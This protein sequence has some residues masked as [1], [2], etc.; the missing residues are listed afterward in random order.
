MA[1]VGQHAMDTLYL[2]WED[3]V[4]RA[5][6]RYEIVK[7]K[8]ARKEYV[9]QKRFSDEVLTVTGNAMDGIE[10]LRNLQ[11]SSLESIENL[12][13]FSNIPKEGMETLKNLQKSS[14]EKLAA[15]NEWQKTYLEKLAENLRK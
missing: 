11:Q 14:M 2:S 3:S 8:Y 15:M 7:E 12:K 1:Q 13:S 10:T 9:S 4:A 6:Q 5:A